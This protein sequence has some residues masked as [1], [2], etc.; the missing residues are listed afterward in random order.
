MS[1]NSFFH[2]RKSRSTIAA[3]QEECN[4]FAAQAPQPIY[5]QLK[6]PTVVEEP[7]TYCKNSILYYMKPMKKE[8][9]TPVQEEPVQEDKNVDELPCRIRKKVPITFI[10]NDI[11]DEFESDSLYPA[12]VH[13]ETKTQVK[14]KK[15]KDNNRTL[16]LICRISLN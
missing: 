1:I 16:L 11:L 3:K 15:K 2:S 7:K 8:T 4:T 6:K 10:W 9:T 12:T 14:K 13:V 5:D